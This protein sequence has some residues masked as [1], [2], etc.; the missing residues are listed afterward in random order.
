VSVNVRLDFTVHLGFVYRVLL[1]PS[2]VEREP[3]IRFPATLALSMAWLV[4][5]SAQNAH[6]DL[7]VL[8][9][10][11]STL[12]YAL[13]VLCAVK[14][15]NSPRILDVLLDSTVLQVLSPPTHLE[16]IPLS[17]HTHA[18]LVLTACQGWVSM[19][20]K[21]VIFYMHSRAQKVFT[22]NLVHHHQWEMGCAHVVFFVQQALQ[23]RVQHLR[24]P[25]LR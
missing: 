10:V 9:S 22:A 13:L 24:A 3:L 7:F 4:R 5:Q 14:L 6:A 2:A 11:E 21:S 20:L 15:P 8:D 1:A 19:K 12:Q 16:T 25:S 18:L 17:D 23:F